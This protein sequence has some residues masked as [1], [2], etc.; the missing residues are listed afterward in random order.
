MIVAGWAPPPAH[1]EPQPADGYY[2]DVKQDL[3][4]TVFADSEELVAEQASNSGPVDRI[5][6]GDNSTF[7][8]TR[9]QGGTAEEKAMPHHF[10]VATASGDPI[11]EVGQV[12]LTDRGGQGSG[13]VKDFTVDIKPTGPC[14]DG[15]DGWQRVGQQSVSAAE[16]GDHSV[17]F[18][19]TN[20][21]CVRVTYQSAWNG[22][23]GPSEFASLA[24]FNLGIIHPGEKPLP[25]PAPAPDPTEVRGRPLA[26]GAISSSTILDPLALDSRRADNPD[27]TPIALRIGKGD[28]ARIVG[29]RVSDVPTVAATGNSVGEDFH[30]DCSAKTDSPDGSAAHPYTSIAQINR[31]SE[32]SPGDRILFKRG[33]VCAGLLHPKGSGSAEH[34]ITIDAYGDSS[35]PAPRLEG[36]GLT[37]SAG[38]DLPSGL[39]GKGIESAVVRFFNQQYWNVRNL[40]IT[41]YSGD[42]ADY[43]NRRRGVV[44]AIEDFGRAKGF[45]LANLY[46]HDVLGAGDKDLGGSGGIQF[47]AYA[48]AK[49]V[50]SSF[51]DLTVRYNRIRHVN[52]S[53][54]NEGSN[55]RSR[56]SVGGSINDNPFEVWGAMDVHDNIVSDIGGDAIVTQFA[57]GS[58]VH[59]NTVWNTSNHH[60]GRSASGN[61]AAVWAWDA[62]HVRFHHNHVFDT[63]MPSGTQDGTAF[64]ADYGTT[65][66]TFEHNV[67]HDNEG[68]FMLFCGCGGLSTKTILR[69]NISINDGRGAHSVQGPRAFFVAGQADGEVYNNTFLA[70]PGVNLDKGASDRSAITY[71]NNVIWAQGEVSS[72]SS[73]AENPTSTFRSNLFLGTASGWPQVEKN[74]LRGADSYPGSGIG[75][76]IPSSDVEA[77]GN[78]ILRTAMTDIRGRAVPMWQRPDR[79]AFQVAADDESPAVHNGGFEHDGVTGSSASG[80][81]LAGNAAVVADHRGG[82]YSLEVAGGSAS[83][84]VLVG[85][86]RTVRLVAAVKADS[87]GAVPVVTL[88][89]PKGLSVNAELVAA[90]ADE[91]G[92]TR[93]SAVMR[94]AFDGEDLTVQVSGTG[95]VDDVALHLVDD[96]VVD[97]SFESVT[98]T[99]WSSWNTS[100]TADSVS[101]ARALTVKGP[102][103]SENAEVVVPEVGVTY[104]AYGWART[105]TGDQAVRMGIK[106]YSD[107]ADDIYKEF[108]N[109]SWEQGHAD[110]TPENARFTMYCYLPGGGS[111]SC[112]DISLVRQWDGEVVKI[113]AESTEPEPSVE[114]SVDPSGEPS[115]EPS[116]V[117]SAQPSEV[118]STQPS[119][120]PSTSGQ[121]GDG[122][123]HGPGASSKPV[124]GRPVALPRTGC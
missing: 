15:A 101:G 94:T 25:E 88:K 100:R 11:S 10:I 7:W 26:S 8:H 63:V 12:T 52:R 44:V 65:G 5:L 90:G 81:T 17:T 108:S 78:P 87:H 51:G 24:E 1:A 64:D 102:G 50:P 82:N 39:T 32:F 13:R 89:N 21:A 79:G 116:V 61:N 47:E 104:T 96:Y 99:T 48:G 77:A 45:D 83:Q 3:L 43:R 14:D 58:Q 118:P 56:P 97:G 69:Y 112:D 80:W 115:V 71:Q 37:E 106:K 92:W 107:G 42:S 124:G 119:T 73:Q 35:A 60:G 93:V 34:R 120:V 40:E 95:A 67:S 2:V 74:V 6:D 114:P 86:N 46:I 30:V 28:S 19:P 4:K 70:Y 117:P 22:A 122:A 54:I 55:F 41:N 105:A 76:L 72:G 18:A 23:D 27:S 110:V 75:G 98:S 57:S 20:V 123:S 121:P 84:D 103:S 31:H 16:K 66:T 9:W 109:S 113:A 68:G 33:T 62:D 53:G 38:N 85:A 36:R 91:D 29:A 49:K 59:H 111:A